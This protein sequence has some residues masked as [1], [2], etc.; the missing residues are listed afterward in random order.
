METIEIFNIFRTKYFVHIYVQN[1]FRKMQ[2]HWFQSSY[3]DTKEKF[4][5]KTDFALPSYSLQ[6]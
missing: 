6:L 4:S 2:F 1:I 3:W 5:G